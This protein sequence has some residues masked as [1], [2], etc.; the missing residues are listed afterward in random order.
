MNSGCQYVFHR[1]SLAL[2]PVELAFFSSFFSPSL[3]QQEAGKTRCVCV[4]C[5]RAGETRPEFK[6]RKGGRWG[7]LVL[8]VYATQSCFSLSSL[9]L[10][11]RLTYKPLLFFSLVLFFSFGVPSS[12]CTPL[13]WC[14]STF[15]QPVYVLLFFFL[16][17][18]LQGDHTLPLPL[19]L[20][21]STHL[22]SLLHSF[23]FLIT[24]SLSLSC[25]HSS[26]CV[27]IVW[28]CTNGREFLYSPMIG[29]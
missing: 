14:G 2:W 24:L 13:H 26:V 21:R 11:G 28:V 15:F 19:A 9:W 10:M 5:W 4:V 23:C 29:W 7:L 12:W 8:S 1:T 6:E 17:L 3:T 22:L 27:F 16:L 25:S 20:I 18:C